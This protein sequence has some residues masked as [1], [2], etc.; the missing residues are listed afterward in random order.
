LRYSPALTAAAAKPLRG[1][2]ALPVG[3]LGSANTAYPLLSAERTEW[4][5]AVFNPARRLGFYFGLA[6]IFLRFSM[7][8]ESITILTHVNTYLALLTGFPAIL[9]SIAGGGL[10]RV[11]HARTGKFWLAF[12]GFVTLS[13]PFSSWR[14]E[15]FNVLYSYLRADFPTLFI[16]GGMVLTWKE[17]KTVLNALALSGVCTLAM[18][19]VFSNMED[20]G[21]M[22]LSGGTIG[23]SNDYAAH[24]LLLLPF[25][26]WIVLM[27]GKRIFKIVCLPLLVTGLFVD[28]KAG[29]RGALI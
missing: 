1:S 21:R 23:N 28:L 20:N 6:F 29:S 9:L 27:P 24:L 15:S 17:C 16:L 18:E 4:E 10:A 3:P 5:A 11:W 14:G 7:L 2:A 12:L 19:K 25:I 26:L 13:I 22:S 8:H